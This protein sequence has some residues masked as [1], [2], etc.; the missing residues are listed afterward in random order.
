MTKE[1]LTAHLEP[2]AYI[3]RCPEQVDEFLG[4]CVAPVL[5]R[6]K[7]LLGDAEVDLKV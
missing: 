3:G 1:E 4:T 7:D 5:A 2:S 6:Y